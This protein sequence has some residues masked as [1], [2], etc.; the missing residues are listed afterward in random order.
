MNSRKFADRIGNIDDRLVQQ[1]ERLPDYRAQRRRKNFM[2]LVSWA[3]TLVLMVCSF[4]TGATVF[5]R[6]TIVGQEM[7]TLEE[8]GL[9]LILPDQWKGNYI[10]EIGEMDGGYLYTFYDSRIHG[11]GGEWTDGGAL[12]YVGAYGS[13]PMTEEELEMANVLDGAI[14]YKYLFSTRATNYIMV[15]VT[16]IQYNPNDEEMTQNYK[17]LVKGIPSIRFVLDSVLE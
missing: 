14:P 7:V 11:Q 2:R 17:E 1:A 12:F 5:A 16:D 8:I 13:E 6:E 4:V 9:T 15:D 10:V 3:A